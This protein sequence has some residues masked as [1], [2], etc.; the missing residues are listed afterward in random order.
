MLR[1]VQDVGEIPADR[2][3]AAE[4]WIFIAG[5]L[6]AATADRLG[7]PLSADEFAAIKAQRRRWLFGAA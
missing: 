3:V 6:L 7:G 2:D 1:A 5:S 4:A